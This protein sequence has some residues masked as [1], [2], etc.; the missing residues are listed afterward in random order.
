M[1]GNHHII[2][3]KECTLITSLIGLSDIEGKREIKYVFE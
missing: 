2:G 1:V 3:S